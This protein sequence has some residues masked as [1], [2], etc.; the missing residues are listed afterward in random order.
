M[1][2]HARHFANSLL[3]E[4]VQ[5]GAGDGQVI[6]LNNREFVD[7]HFQLFA[8]ATYQN[9]LLLQ[10]ADQLQNPADIVNG[11][12]ADL[13]GAFHYDLRTD[14]VTGEQFLQ[15]CAIFLI[16][17]QM[18]APY[19]TATGFHCPTQ[20]AHCAGAVIAFLFLQLNARLG[21]V[22]KQ[23]G[24]NIAIIVGDALRGAKAD[25]FLCLQ[26]DSQLRGDLF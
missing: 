24:N 25:H 10:R 6:A 15:Q 21:F 11:S 12:A 13:L 19:P 9:A 1:H 16:A 22:R 23:L 2:R 5:S 7:L 17:D 14:P 20:E 4:R 26:F 8:G 18:A 3:R